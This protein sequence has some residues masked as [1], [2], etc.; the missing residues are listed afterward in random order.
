QTA[1]DNPLAYEN[2]RALYP[3]ENRNSRSDPADFAPAFVEIAEGE[4]CFHECDR[5]QRSRRY[6]ENCAR[7]GLCAARGA[8][9]GLVQSGRERRRSARILGVP[10][11]VYSIAAS[12]DRYRAIAK[13]Y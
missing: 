1:D 2:R 5:R 3:R 12:F 4:P 13:P 9:R 11:R 8:R 6:G 7:G 10:A